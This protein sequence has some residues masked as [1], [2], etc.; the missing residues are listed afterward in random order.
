MLIQR[1]FISLFLFTL[2]G[3]I[4]ANN[5]NCNELKNDRARE[6]CWERQHGNNN[7]SNNR[8]CNDI[9]NDR[10]RER[11]WEE[12]NNSNNNHR[13]CNDLKNERARERCRNESNHSSNW[14]R[15]SRP[16]SSSGRTYSE[17]QS[18][19]APAGRA[20]DFNQCM[21]SQGFPTRR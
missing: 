19:C 9:K 3:F 14:N 5:R 8:N 16:S 12:R 18:F 17:A 2:S 13:N 7:N 1:L 21:T 6:I 4:F 20:D 15:P 10:A 11:C